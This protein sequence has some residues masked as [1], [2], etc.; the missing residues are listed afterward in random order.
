[1]STLGRLRGVTVIATLFSLGVIAPACAGVT[2]DS[3]GAGAAVSTD[4]SVFASV[5]PVSDIAISFSKSALF[6]PEEGALRDGTEVEATF[7]APSL[8]LRTAVPILL[9]TRG[10]TSL[11]EGECS[12]PKLSFKFKNKSDIAASA[13]KGLKRITTGEN[14]TPSDRQ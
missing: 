14:S 10:N 12:F 6:V 11:I 4:R 1:M 8:G 7:K 3:E 13:F 9:K 5:D 2:D